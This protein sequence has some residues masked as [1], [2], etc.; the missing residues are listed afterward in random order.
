VLLVALDVPY[1]EPLHRLR[2]LPGPAGVALVLAPPDAAGALARVAI[3]LVDAT[4]AGPLSACA[5]SGLDAL[6]SQVPAAAALPLLEA[7]A[8]RSIEQAVVLGYLPTLALRAVVRR[9]G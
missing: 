4:R 2:P 9:P 7:I 6:R 1:P 8:R 3:G 5:D